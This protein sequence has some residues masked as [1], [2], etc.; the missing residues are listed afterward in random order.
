MYGVALSDLYSD[1]AFR[2]SSEQLREQ[3]LRSLKAAE[4]QIEI[5]RDKL[6]WRDLSQGEATICV[7]TSL[8][9]EKP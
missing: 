5:L 2:T 9:R 4:L 8:K 6:F 7:A 3:R 1:A